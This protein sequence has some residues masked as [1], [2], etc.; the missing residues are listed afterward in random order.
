M[1]A[2]LSILG[3]YRPLCDRSFFLLA[4]HA[5]RSRNQTNKK[6]NDVGHHHLQYEYY[7]RSPL[8]FQYLQTQ[9]SGKQKRKHDKSTINS[10]IKI[11]AL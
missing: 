11:L 10:G 2:Y 9:T 5:R 8:L 4:G 1:D 6:Q 7:R 3:Y